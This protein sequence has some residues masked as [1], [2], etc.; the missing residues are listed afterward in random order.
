MKLIKTV[1]VLVLVLIFSCSAFASSTMS[2][3]FEL[4]NNPNAES[5]A[6]SIAQAQEKLKEKDEDR[7]GRT[8]SLEM[9]QDMLIRSL[10][11]Q[12]TS[13]ISLEVFGEEGLILPAHYT[14]GTYQIDITK[15]TEDGQDYLNVMITDIVTDNTTVIKVPY[16]ES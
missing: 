13:K 3:E 6:L 14:I 1:V 8:D 5:V 15:V 10:L 12:V 16:I 2:W 11:T 9:F 7:F 4:Y